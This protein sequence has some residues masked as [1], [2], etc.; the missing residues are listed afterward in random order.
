MGLYAFN[1]AHQWLEAGH[2]AEG[3][4]STRLPEPIQYVHNCL[5][6]TTIDR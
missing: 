1:I 5:V 2:D 3:E 4:K 6:C